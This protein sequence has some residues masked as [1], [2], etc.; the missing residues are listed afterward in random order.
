MTFL[1]GMCRDAELKHLQVQLDNIG[2]DAGRIVDLEAELA[3]AMSQVAAK[4]CADP[5]LS[6]AIQLPMGHAACSCCCY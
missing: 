5:C 3:T 1:R 6:I 2:L 4:V